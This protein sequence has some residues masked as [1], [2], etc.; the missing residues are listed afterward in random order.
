MILWALGIIYIPCKYGKVINNVSELVICIGR[1]E[2]ALLLHT[3]S[4]VKINTIMLL[5]VYN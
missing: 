4:R 3:S 5:H 2:S 1:C